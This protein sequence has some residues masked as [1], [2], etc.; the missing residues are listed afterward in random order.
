[1]AWHTLV[2]S[3]NEPKR[4]GV[5]DHKASIDVYLSGSDWEWR[6]VHP[7]GRYIGEVKG[8]FNTEDEAKNDAFTSLNGILWED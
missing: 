3:E 5:T 4:L 1:M 6:E 7:N 2:L 8:P